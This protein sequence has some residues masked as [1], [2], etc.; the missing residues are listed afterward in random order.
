MH[1]SLS[2]LGQVPGGAETVIRALLEAV[3]RDGTLLMPALGNDTPGAP[4][5]FDVVNTPTWVGAIA[6]AFRVRP[7]TMRSLHPTHSVCA[8]GKLA[9]ELL[10]PHERD[11]TPCGPNSPF[12]RLKDYGGQI[13]ML[14]CGLNP[15]T[16]FHAIEELFEPPYLFTGKTQT[17]TLRH[18]NG[19]VIQKEY[20]IHDFKGYEQ[21]YERIEQLLTPPD[22]V[23][24]KVLEAKAYLLN[25]ATMWNVASAA[26]EKDSLFFVDRMNQNT[27]IED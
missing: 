17:C 20:A 7:A 27:K 25:A 3:G 11:S 9:D 2:S 23:K 26:M 12:H 19:N 21:H 16:S 6:E 10:T 15:N 5:K 22:L 24:G 4:P 8:L 14:G 1:S 13:L 18:S